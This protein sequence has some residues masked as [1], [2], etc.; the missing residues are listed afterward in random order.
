MTIPPIARIRVQGLASIAD[1]ELSLTTPVTALIGANG[2]GKSNFIRSLDLLG[3]IVDRGLQG[4]L[5][6]RGGFSR[7]LHD[8]PA[9]AERIL[10]R[11]EGAV[12]GDGI[13][14]GYEA[15]LYAADDDAATLHETLI[16]QDTNRYSN[17]YTQRIGAA[18]ESRLAKLD[19]PRERAFARHVLT[20]LGGCR[21]Y[22]FDDV[23]PD[24]PPKRQRPVSDNLELARD[25]ANLAPYLYRLRDEEPHAYRG[26][27]DAVRAVAPFFNDFVLEP[28]G[29]DRDSLMLRW[30][31]EGSASVFAASQ[32]SDGTLRFICLATLLMSPHRPA[33][34][35][36]DEPEL[37]LHPFA[38][39]QL[40]ELL[41]AASR[42]ER[43][44]ILATQSTELL[45][46]FTLDEI[47][48]IER[49]DGATRIVRAD[50]EQLSAFLDD[51]SIS[52][53]WS[54]NL[55]GGRPA[56]ETSGAQ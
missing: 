1:V 22:H 24:A 49:H 39:H 41:G 30:K 25:A 12:D 11:V 32:L 17:P 18:R 19:D 54:M 55:L 16:M 34:V 14:N 23:S 33:T 44:V 50:V 56:P 15:R 46:T 3:A 27:I 10:L 45:A 48:V 40:A 8:G 4:Y 5:S 13:M 47:A 26:V 28:Q 42:G 29:L 9:P 2:S 6:D 20:V 35:V 51:Y 52:D 21:V 43:R 7:L 31:Q 38:I 53:L 36:L 37:G